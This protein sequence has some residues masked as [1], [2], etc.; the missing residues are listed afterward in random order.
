M[1]PT[2][3]KPAIIF[4]F[5][6]KTRPRARP[7]TKPEIHQR[8]LDQLRQEL[9]AITASAKSSFAS[10]TDEANRSEHKYDTFKLEESFLARGQARRVKD[11]AA[12]LESLQ[13]LPVN[14]LPKGSPV[15]FGALIRLK[16]GSG[17]SSTLLFGSAAGGETLVVDGEE[18]TVVTVQSPLGQALSGKKAGESFELKVGPA[19]QTFEI[20]SVE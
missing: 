5:M 14:E 9:D 11:L 10:A 7:V 18:I 17:T 4:L 6:K 15:Q 19:L 12:A 8:F 16:A 13:M 20:F 1:A 2:A 3:G